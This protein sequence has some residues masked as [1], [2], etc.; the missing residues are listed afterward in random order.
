MHP[1][2]AR[3]ALITARS[4]AAAKDLLTRFSA[5]AVFPDLIAELELRHP[6]STNAI[7][8]VAI[9]D[10]LNALVGKRDPP[11]GTPRRG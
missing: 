5:H 10:A 8:A 11:G 3:I 9:I 4:T 1:L 7:S 2:E 6:A